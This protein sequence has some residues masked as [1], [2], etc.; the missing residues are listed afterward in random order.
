LKGFTAKIS[1]LD[2]IGGHIP[3]DGPLIIVTASFEGIIYDLIPF[4]DLSRLSGEPPDN[5]GHFVQYLKDLPKQKELSNVQYTVFGCGN[6]EWVNTY[7]KIPK[8]CDTLLEENG[9]VR[10]LPRGEADAGGASFFEEFDDWE[11]KLWPVLSE[12]CLIFSLSAN[13]LDDDS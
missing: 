10:I 5:A 11:A 8:L 13:M 2:F 7:Q 12:V 6:H 1:T 3:S 4:N 9:A